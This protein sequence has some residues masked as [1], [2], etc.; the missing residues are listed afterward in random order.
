MET[1]IEIKGIIIGQKEYDELVEIKT[2]FNEGLIPLIKTSYGTTYYANVPDFDKSVVSVIES[3][4]Q[5]IAV[6]RQ[7]LTVAE[8]KK[9]A[10][11]I[12]LLGFIYL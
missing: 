12:N 4:Q 8:N 5:Q 3:Q 11:G 7:E 10:Y 1:K 2:K 6:L 9:N